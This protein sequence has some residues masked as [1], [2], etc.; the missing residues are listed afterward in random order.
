MTFHIGPDGIEASYGCSL[1]VFTF[2]LVAMLIVLVA[3]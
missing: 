3:R 1:T 2:L